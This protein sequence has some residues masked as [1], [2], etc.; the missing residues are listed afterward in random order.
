MATTRLTG[1]RKCRKIGEKLCSGVAKCALE[2]RGMTPGQHGKKHATQKSLSIFGRQLKEKQK[3]K[4]LYG[5]NEQQFKRFFSIALKQKGITG[6]NLLSILERRI[7][8]VLFRL[9]MASSRAQARQMIVHGHVLV[10]TKRVSSPS[11]IVSA[12]EEVSLAKR[13]L[14]KEGF[15][16]AVVEKRLGISIKVPEWLEL[17]KQ[18]YSGVV[19]RDPIR[20]DIQTPILEHLIVE[21]YSK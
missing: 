18:D 16:N 1:C 20:T 6:E 10:N 19:L 15:V 4:Y 12:G 3:V 8:N 2:R 13:A 17:R 9:K 5:M 11:Y 14:K 7:D 21:L